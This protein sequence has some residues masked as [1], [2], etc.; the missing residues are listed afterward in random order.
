MQWSCTLQMLIRRKLYIYQ[1][2]TNFVTTSVLINVRQCNNSISFLL[3]LTNKQNV[4]QKKRYVSLVLHKKC[5]NIFLNNYKLTTLIVNETQYF[6][7]EPSLLRFFLKYDQYIK[8]KCFKIVHP[9]SCIKLNK[10]LK[11]R[12]NNEI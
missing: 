12:R 9:F 8:E 1:E 10:L 4:F 11:K 2:P 3:L 6:F 5:N 7:A